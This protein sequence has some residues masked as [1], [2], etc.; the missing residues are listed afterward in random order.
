MGD[1]DAAK[2]EATEMLT[3]VGQAKC[4]ITRYL[5]RL[6]AHDD[7]G[8]LNGDHFKL[9]FDKVQTQ[10]DKLTLYGAN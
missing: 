10:M 1:S 2:A 9:T 4:W 8:T 3:Q 5:K 6:K 7:A